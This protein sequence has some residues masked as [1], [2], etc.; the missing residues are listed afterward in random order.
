MFLSL[1]ADDTAEVRS[2]AACQIRGLT[3][4]L[5]SNSQ[6]ASSSFT[7]GDVIDE[8]MD[9]NAAIGDDRDDADEDENAS[10]ASAAAADAFI[11]QRLLPAMAELNTDSNVHVKAKLGLAVLGLAPLLGRELTITHLLPI[12]L[13]QLKDESPD[14]S[15]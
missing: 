7:S 4:G 2:A 12:I 5:L 1:L 3:S 14:V 8:K 10:S 11:V 13:A 15:C 6:S 9:V